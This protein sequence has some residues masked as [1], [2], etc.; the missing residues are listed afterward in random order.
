[1]QQGVTPQQYNFRRALV[2]T[3]VGFLCLIFMRVF[4]AAFQQSLS[5]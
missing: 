2:E 5:P 4:F 3:Q 1:M